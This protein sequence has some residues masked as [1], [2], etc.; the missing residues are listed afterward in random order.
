MLRQARS[1]CAMG[2]GGG[3]MD[4]VMEMSSRNRGIANGV[5]G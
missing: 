3:R 5:F 2:V 4:D 1:K